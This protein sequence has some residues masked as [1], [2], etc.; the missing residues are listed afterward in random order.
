MKDALDLV[1]TVLICLLAGAWIYLMLLIRSVILELAALRTEL[2]KFLSPQAHQTA[3]KADREDREDGPAAA[4][5]P[6]Q[7]HDR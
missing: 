6:P 4:S 1:Q 2:E 5:Q 3:N 7:G